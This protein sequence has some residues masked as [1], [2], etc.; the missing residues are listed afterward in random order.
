V[1]FV[2][3]FRESFSFCFVTF[4]GDFCESFSFCFVTFVGEVFFV[5]HFLSVL[6]PLLVKSFS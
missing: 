4:V 5:S 3:D 6:W 1:T 2:G